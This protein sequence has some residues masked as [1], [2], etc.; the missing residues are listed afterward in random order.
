MCDEC[1]ILFPQVK[2][3]ETDIQNRVARIKDEIKISTSEYEKEKLQE[4]LARLASGVALLKVG[5]SSEVR[6]A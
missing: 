3:K 4:R 5:G 2:G 1:I 6:I